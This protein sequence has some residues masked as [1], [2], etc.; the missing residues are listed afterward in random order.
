VLH[1]ITIGGDPDV[2]V[3]WDSSQ[4]D[5]RSAN[6]LNFS[7]YKSSSSDEALQAGR[8][9]IDPKLRAI[10]YH[11]F[12]TNWKT[13]AP[14]MGLYQPRFLYITRGDVYGLNDHSINTGIGRFSNVSDWMIRTAGITE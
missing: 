6:R 10:K 13:D 7:E 14:A 8:S 2:F 4:T 11:A 1:G 9:T 3:Y 5:I 12:L